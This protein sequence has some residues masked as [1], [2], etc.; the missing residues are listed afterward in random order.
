MHQQDSSPASN[1]I[2]HAVET[3][4]PPLQSLRSL[5]Y[6]NG[7]YRWQFSAIALSVQVLAN[8]HG[9]LADDSVTDVVFVLEY[10]IKAG[11]ELSS[12][13]AAKSHRRDETSIHERDAVSRAIPGSSTAPHVGR[14]RS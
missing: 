5:H 9:F 13:E 6:G 10:A 7:V 14:D 4:Y 11:Q 1:C 2:E 8:D 12:R 3:P